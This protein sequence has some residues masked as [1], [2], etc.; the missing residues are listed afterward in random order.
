MAAETSEVKSHA[1]GIDNGVKYGPV[2]RMTQLGYSHTRGHTIFTTLANL[3]VCDQLTRETA[4]GGR[5][6]S[7]LA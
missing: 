1:A 4:G 2:E 6:G 3:H 5:G 7:A